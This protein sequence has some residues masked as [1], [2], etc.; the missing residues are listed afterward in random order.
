LISDTVSSEIF[1][2]ED[3]PLDLYFQYSL[4]P[5]RCHREIGLRLDNEERLLPGP[6]HP[7]QQHQEHPIRPSAC[8]SFHVSA[9]DDEL[10]TRSECLLILLPLWFIR[11]GLNTLEDIL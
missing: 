5:W 3:P 11:K 1:G 10:L 7:S 2:W 9:Q 8:W 6:N 4:N